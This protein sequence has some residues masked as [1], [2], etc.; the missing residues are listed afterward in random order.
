LCRALAGSLLQYRVENCSLASSS[1]LGGQA[2][3]GSCAS[4]ETAGDEISLRSLPGG[5]QRSLSPVCLLSGE[6][7]S[8]ALRRSSRRRLLEKQ[9]SENSSL[10]S[11]EALSLDQVVIPYNKKCRVVYQGPQFFAFILPS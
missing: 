2:T 7:V 3:P 6:E 8:A 1:R 5:G 4:A 10:L 9:N 11:G